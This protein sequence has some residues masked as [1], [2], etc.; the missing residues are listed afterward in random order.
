MKGGQVIGAT[1][2]IGYTAVERPVHPND[3]QATILRLM[4]INQRE[5]YYEHNGRR[6]IVTFNGG[7]VL[8]EVFV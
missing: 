6:E 3:L 2:E 1:D 8:P 7:E 5:L 4:G